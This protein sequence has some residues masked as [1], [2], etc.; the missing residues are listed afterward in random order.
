MHDERSSWLRSSRPSTKASSLLA[1]S[2]NALRQV[3]YSGV[4]TIKTS[5][6]EMIVDTIVELLPGKDGAMI[7]PLVE[8]L[9]KTLRALLEHQPHV[10]RVSKE[11]WE[12]TVEF[13]VQALSRIFAEVDAEPQNSWSTTIS[14]LGPT[15]FE[16]T[17]GGRRDSP[18]KRGKQL[19]QEL[20]R[21]AEE[22]VHCL[23]LLVK[24]SNSPVLDK[25]EVVLMSTVYFLQQNGGRGKAAA[26]A[27]IN[28][29]L[30]RITLHATQLT[31]QVVQELIPLM[32]SMW[33]DPLLREEIM[34]TLI[35]TEAHIASMLVSSRDDSFSF[36]LEALVETMYSDYRRRQDTTAHQY[37]ED[38]HLCFRGLG[39]TE[40]GSHPLAT[41]AFSTKTDQVRYEGLWATIATIA[42]FSYLL[43]ERKHKLTQGR[44]GGEDSMIKRPRVTHHFQ[45]YLRHVSEPRS[46]AKRAAL[47]VVTFMAEEG[48]LDEE[49]LL[50]L[51]ERLTPCISDE[52]P[53]HSSWAMIGLAT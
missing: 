15:P 46:N 50:S 20:V 11:C 25:A 34:I 33:S 3:V 32:K 38:D 49:D 4:R 10:E 6:V 52:N 31:E 35:Y 19:P 14:S 44:E 42:R 16:S 41:C 23:H 28:S 27:A 48:R 21:A 43:D 36:Q 47:Q 39:S 7:K 12:A 26:L 51:L 37:L 53:A 2:A 18:S 30:P 17:D 40:K 45:E 13:C 1:L 29:I 8:D 9:P 24:A 5:T 22:L